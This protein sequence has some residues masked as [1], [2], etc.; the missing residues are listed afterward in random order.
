MV[1]ENRTLREAGDLPARTE[2]NSKHNKSSVSP[3]CH[4]GFGIAD[5]ISQVMAKLSGNG[6]NISAKLWKSGQ[7]GNFLGV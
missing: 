4:E 6:S 1:C 3:V 5:T 2:T 7:F